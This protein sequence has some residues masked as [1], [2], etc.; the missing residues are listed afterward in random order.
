[1][2]YYSRRNVWF[3]GCCQ[4]KYKFDEESTGDIGRDLCDVCDM[5]LPSKDVKIG[6]WKSKGSIPK[7]EPI[8]KTPAKKK[9][10]KIE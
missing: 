8:N 9:K 4:G 3:N 5:P 1:M 10:V 7:A 2:G 6:D